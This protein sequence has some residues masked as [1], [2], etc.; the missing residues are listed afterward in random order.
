MDRVGGESEDGASD[1]VT[2]LYLYQRKGR[3]SEC[4]TAL[5]NKTRLISFLLHFDRVL[6]DDSGA[7]RA[8]PFIGLLGA[9]SVSWRPGCRSG[10]SFFPPDAKITRT[11]SLTP[12]REHGITSHHITSHFAG[13]RVD[14][15]VSSLQLRHELILTISSWPKNENGIAVGI[16][17]SSCALVPTQL[18]CHIREIYLH[19]LRVTL[20]GKVPCSSQVP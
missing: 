14:E 12:I 9:A 2:L 1:S 7:T 11:L 3:A 16:S 17:S 8:S 10:L 6:I 5:S 13:R 20:G 18:R 4:E 19:P 15:Q